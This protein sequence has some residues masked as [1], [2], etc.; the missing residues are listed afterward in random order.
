METID[1]P[2]DLEKLL[3]Q[4]GFSRREAML[5]TS[6]GWPALRAFREHKIESGLEERPRSK[7]SKWLSAK[8]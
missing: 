4:H 2:R 6:G 3:K 8:C 1:S 5:L 7:V